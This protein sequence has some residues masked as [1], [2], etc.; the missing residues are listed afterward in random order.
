[1]YLFKELAPQSSNERRGAMC[2]NQIHFLTAIGL[3]EKMHDPTF[4]LPH[5]G[6][7]DLSGKRE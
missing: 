6:K 7:R 1:M 5:E 2:M 3:S 4:Q